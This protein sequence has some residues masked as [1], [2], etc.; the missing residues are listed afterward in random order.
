MTTALVL[1]AI[2]GALGAF[3]T[4]Y[5]HEWKLQLPSRPHARLELALHGSRDL[6]YTL[7]FGTIGWLTWNGALVWVFGLLLAVEIV[8]TL[9]DFVEEDRTRTLPAGERVMHAIM[10]IV[11]G[12]FLAHLLPAVAGWARR[13]TGFGLANHGLLTWLLTLMAA[14]VFLSGVRDLASALRRA[15]R[16]PSLA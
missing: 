9:W 15:K 7:L 3:D 5:Y 8:I 6:A 16:S 12:A 14:G 11:Y 2:Q 13:P 4:L 10:G 1:L